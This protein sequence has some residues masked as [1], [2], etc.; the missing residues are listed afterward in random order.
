MSF[1]IALRE[2]TDYVANYAP[3]FALVVARVAGLFVM[4]P[5]LGSTRIPKRVRVMLVLMLAL[6]MAGAITSPPPM[7]QDLATLTLALGGEIVFG[8]A[9]GMI[10]SFVFIAAQWAGE[11]MGQQMGL[12]I[13]QTFDP[14]F[15]PSSSLVGDLHFMLCLLIF[16]SPFVNGPAT[17]LRGVHASFVALPL[18]SVG[19]DQSLFTLLVNLFAASATLAF[20]L[21]APML[22]TMLI[23]DAALGVLGKTMPQLNIMS[24]GLSIRAMVGMF[25]L[26]FG[27]RTCADVLTDAVIV[28]TDGAAAYY[29]TP[30]A[31]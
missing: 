16:I 29:A 27:I 22:V 23:V 17:L 15:G 2:F 4:L 7:P 5:F 6:G 13:A 24:A 20:Q 1:E 25:V 19:L 3:A 21:A 28:N 11:I 9:M 18:M 12:Q 26:I 10:V 14:Q 30:R 31:N 8:I